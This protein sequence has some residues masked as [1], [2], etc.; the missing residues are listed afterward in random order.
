MTTTLKEIRP[1]GAEEEVARLKANVAVWQQDVT[2]FATEADLKLG[3]SQTA[4]S[5]FLPQP[6]YS[7]STS[8]TEAV[9]RNAHY[10]LLVSQA[11]MNASK[12]NAR[13]ACDNLAEV[14]GRLGE[15]LGQIGGLDVQKQNVSRILLTD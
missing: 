6:D 10:R 15:I 12:E 9:V 5:G 11:Q 8:V 14:T 1:P 3:T 2:T 7:Q 13:V 4:S